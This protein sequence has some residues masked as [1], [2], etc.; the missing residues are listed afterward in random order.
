MAPTKLHKPSISLILL[1]HNESKNLE[2][3]FSWLDSCKRIKEII[4]IDDNSTDNTVEIAKKLSGKNRLVKVFNRELAI[5]FSTQRNF[6]ISKTKY[7]WTLWLDAD[8]YPD[9]KLILFLNH[10]DKFKYN[11]YSFKRHDIFLKHEL[12]YGETAYLDFTRLF[13][14]KYGHFVGKVHERWQ[15]K[16]IVKETEF[17]IHHNSHSTLK[18]FI[19]KINFY[20]DIRSQELFHQKVTTNIF[21]IIFFPI[22]KFLQNYFFRLGF[23]DGTP[24]I[25]MALSMSFHVFLSKA[26]LWHLYQQ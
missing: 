23:L 21:E 2:N 16:K 24:G 14:K 9:K 3:N 13:N 19:Q 25:I 7:N 18:S 6:A 4:V 17:V 22:G 15:S 26:K 20:S 11:N 10:I 5:D 8:E 12:K 1:T